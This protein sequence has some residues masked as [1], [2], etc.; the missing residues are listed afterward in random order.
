MSE[1]YKTKVFKLG[2]AAHDAA[3][4]ILREQTRSMHDPALKQI[5]DELGYSAGVR[6]NHP[7][8]GN[9]FIFPTTRLSPIGKLEF[10]MVCPIGEK[11]DGTYGHFTPKD[12]EEINLGISQLVLHGGDMVFKRDEIVLP[13]SFGTSPHDLD[14]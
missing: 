3:L 8:H 10:F 13:P 12:S 14:M 7:Q 4:S 6:A 5:V 2:G 9:S 11:N 1:T